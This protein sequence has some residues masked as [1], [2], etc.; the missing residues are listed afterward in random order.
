M[1]QVHF[2]FEDGARHGRDVG[3]GEGTRDVILLSEKHFLEQETRLLDEISSLK[4]SRDIAVAK[5][6]AL[7]EGKLYHIC[8][9]DSDRILKAEDA[10]ER[11]SRAFRENSRTF[12]QQQAASARTQPGGRGTRRARKG[13]SRYLL[14]VTAEES[15]SAAKQTRTREKILRCA[16]ASQANGIGN[17][18]TQSP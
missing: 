5:A 15:G 4:A 14:R 6:S 10:G 11:E 7:E 9:V 2:F 12:H 3:A 16:R 1:T 8:L 18:A 13:D 17:C